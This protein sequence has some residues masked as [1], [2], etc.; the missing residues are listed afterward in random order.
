[1]GSGERGD[2]VEGGWRDMKRPER[3]AKVSAEVRL[4]MIQADLRLSQNLAYS[5]NVSPR[6][7]CC[8]GGKD[9]EDSSEVSRGKVVEHLKQDS[10]A[11]VKMIER[12]DENREDANHDGRED[13]FASM[14][15]DAGDLCAKKDMDAFVER[16]I[17]IHGR[18]EISEERGKGGGRL[19]TLAQVSAQV[20]GIS[21]EKGEMF[22][23]E[24]RNMVKST[25][26]VGQRESQR[27]DGRP[28]RSCKLPAHV[29]ISKVCVNSGPSHRIWQPSRERNLFCRSA[30][31]CGAG[32]IIER[33]A[34]DAQAEEKCAEKR[35]WN[36]KEQRREI[37]E[38][39]VASVWESS[40][41]R[42]S[43]EKRRRSEW[44]DRGVQ[45][46]RESAVQRAGERC[47]SQTEHLVDGTIRRERRAKIC[48]EFRLAMMGVDTTLSCSG[49]ERHLAGTVLKEQRSKGRSCFDGAAAGGADAHTSRK[50]K[51]PDGQ[52]G[53][54]EWVGECVW[55]RGGLK[56]YNAF[57]KHGQEVAVGECV[58]VKAEEKGRGSYMMRVEEIWGEGDAVEG[59]F[60]GSW[61]YR[62]IETVQGVHGAMHPREVYLSDWQDVN[63]LECVEALCRITFFKVRALATTKA[64]CHAESLWGTPFRLADY[65]DLLW[66]CTCLEPASVSE[67]LNKLLSIFLALPSNHVVG[68][69]Q[70]LMVQ[71]TFLVPII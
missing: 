71:K 8:I 38:Q 27:Q 20:R 1:M 2:T 7:G 24:R 57:R 30:L 36:G 19:E 17:D 43:C 15:S 25:S 23:G 26:D 28:E 42:S 14:S 11:R 22:V 54:I 64:V 61:L 39:D 66:C 59:E 41:T 58:Y 32:G 44:V 68:F 3:K 16:S 49:P 6:R 63:P 21:V 52:E 4:A 60:R 47:K 46:G 9:A 31:S 10:S 56:Y 45:R 37:V 29:K 51:Q 35:G 48:A 5:I 13:N 69:N 34:R 12:E 53:E 55:E 40:Q 65:K 62:P 33:Q 50:R 70:S 67:R 18:D